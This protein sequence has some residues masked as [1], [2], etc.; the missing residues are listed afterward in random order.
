MIDRYKLLEKR[1]ANVH[2]HLSLVAIENIAIPI[3]R[4]DIEVIGQ[5]VDDIFPT[6]EFILR[7]VDLKIDTVDLLSEA[8]GFD[9]VARRKF[10]RF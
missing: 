8:L 10:T 7:F 2:N 4:L 6:T 5:Q 1:F 9:K 3:T